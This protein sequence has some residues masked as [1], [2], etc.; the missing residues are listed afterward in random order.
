MAITHHDS[1]VELSACALEGRALLPAETLK[2]Q[3]SKR[4]RRQKSA[5]LATVR[6][7]KCMGSLAENYSFR[8]GRRQGRRAQRDNYTLSQFMYFFDPVL[9]RRAA[10]L[11]EDEALWS[12]TAA[13]KHTRLRYRHQ[14]ILRPRTQPAGVC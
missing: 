13:A 5:R 7:K 6:K 8:T 10:P 4:T 14:E 1:I 12:P 3:A 2:R 11:V 9:P